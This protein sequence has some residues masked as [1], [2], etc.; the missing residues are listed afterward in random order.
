VE[1]DGLDGIAGRRIGRLRVH[2]DG[3]RLAGICGAVEVD[4][5]DTFRVPED[6]NP[7]AAPNVPD[8]IGSTAW[9]DEVDLPLQRQKGVASRGWREAGRHPSESPETRR[10]RRERPKGRQRP[11]APIPDPL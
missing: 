2:D 8:E 10:A 5:A 11:S 3:N 4:V 7:G 1:Q 6:G 9:D